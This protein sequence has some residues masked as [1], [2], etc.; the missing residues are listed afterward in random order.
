MACHLFGRLRSLHRLTF[1]VRPLRA[2]HRLTFRFRPLH[3]SH[4]VFFLYARGLRLEKECD[5]VT[6]CVHALT[7]LH[8]NMDLHANI[9]GAT[10]RV[11]SRDSLGVCTVQLS[12]YPS[13]IRVKTQ[14]PGLAHLLKLAGCSVLNPTSVVVDVGRY[15][16]TK[17][18]FMGV[19][20]TLDN[21]HQ[22]LA[23][24]DSGTASTDQRHLSM[25]P[26]MT[27]SRRMQPMVL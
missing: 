15:D 7:V 17:M 26:G 19:V 3:S 12:G 21:N 23:M 10:G 6:L 22:G 13:I 24:T 2:P 8:T 20:C 16:A 18:M 5:Q 4:R 9:V 27:P 11:F 1:R 25:N 14:Q